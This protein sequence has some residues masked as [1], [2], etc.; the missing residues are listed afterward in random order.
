M[1]TRL[2]LLVDAAKNVAACCCPYLRSYEVCYF[3]DAHDWVEEEVRA[4]NHRDAAKR[5]G[6]IA[7]RNCWVR[8]VIRRR[9]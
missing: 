6:R 8:R 9:P 4:Y 5:K 1:N 3:N 7:G 2:E